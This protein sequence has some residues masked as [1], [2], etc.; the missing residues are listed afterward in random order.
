[1]PSRQSCAALRPVTSSP[2]KRTVP[3]LGRRKPDRTL[4]SVVLPAPFGPTMPTASRG[5]RLKSTS[6]STTS[7]PNRFRIPAAERTA[8]PSAGC[9]AVVGSAV[10]RLQF[11]ADRHL[12]VVDV[13]DD[14]TLKLVLAALRRLE[15]LAGEQRCRDDVRHLPPGGIFRVLL[16]VEVAD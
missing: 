12:L 16:P 14:H 8:M 9:T 10:V 2:R 4:R 1:M 15:P 6:S 5:S 11:R 7:A 3:A 13:L